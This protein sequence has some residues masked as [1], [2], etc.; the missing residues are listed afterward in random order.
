MSAITTINLFEEADAW[1]L[2]EDVIQGRLPEG[3]FKIDFGDWPEFSFRMEGAKYN[4]SLTTKMMDALIDLQR[5]IYRSYAKLY[6]DDANKRLTEAEKQK[7]EIMVQV[8]PGSTGLKAKLAEIAKQFTQGAINKMEAKHF[9]IVLTTGIL[10]LT[11]QTMWKNYL[12]VQGEAKNV[13]A[14]V[15]LSKEETRRMEIFRDAMVQ[16]SHVSAQKADAEEFYNKV[17][18]S[19]VSSEQVHVAGQ[20]IKKEQLL[21]LVRGSRSTSQ[22]ICL[23][24]VYRI[25]RVD[26]SKPGVFKVDVQ[27][28]KGKKFPAI[29]DESVLITKEQNRKLLQEAEWMKKPISL[30]IDGTEVRGEIT[31]A[32]I[33]DVMDKYVAN[34]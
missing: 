7:L 25:L 31:T 15:A 10:C 8:F 1:K 6:Y 22:E 16:V 23:N 13:N 30:M 28:E 27:D 12:N 20:I 11:G 24:G 33:L 34:R 26:S 5:N 29:L 3:E 14:K 32:K 2:L 9:V 17:L 19:A 18:K 21:Q 4:S